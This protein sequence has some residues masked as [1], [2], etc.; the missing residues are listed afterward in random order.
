M[1]RPNPV[2]RF[3]V[4]FPEA[5]HTFAEIAIS[6]VEQAVP[7]ENLSVLLRRRGRLCSTMFSTHT[8]RGEHLMPPLARQS[9]PECGRGTDTVVAP[10][11]I[12]IH[13]IGPRQLSPEQERLYRQEATTRVG[14]RSY[15]QTYAPIRPYGQ[16]V[17]SRSGHLVGLVSAD[18]MREALKRCPRLGVA[19]GLRPEEI[20]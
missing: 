1:T 11:Q 14:P 16:F 4:A 20:Q 5:E 9:C 15:G 13:V 6:G 3:E 7:A 10:E 12:P 8:T 2:Q 17:V 18:V 19:L